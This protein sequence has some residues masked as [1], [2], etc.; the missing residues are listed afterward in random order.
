M[1]HDCYILYPAPLGSFKE[2]FG[3]GPFGA[4]LKGI[5]HHSW[6]FNH[7]KT[8]LFVSL[9][10]GFEP[11][12]Q[13]AGGKRMRDYMRH[14]LTGVIHIGARQGR[15]D[16]GGDPDRYPALLNMIAHLIVQAFQDQK[17]PGYEAFGLAQ[18]TRHIRLGIIKANHDFLDQFGVFKNFPPAGLGAAH[19]L[20]HCFLLAFVDLGHHPVLS[21]TLQGRHPKETIQKNMPQRVLRN[22]HNRRELAV[23]FQ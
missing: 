23:T 8:V 4:D 7:G 15:Q 10:I 1:R 2:T 18:K 17:A 19:N 20:D 6:V 13:L 22:D 5:Q 14:H 21:Q 11:T 12:H 16:S 9:S 3:F